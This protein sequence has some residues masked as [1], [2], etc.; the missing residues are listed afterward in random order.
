ME[1]T[2]LPGDLYERIIAEL[3]PPDGKAVSSAH[4]V[5]AVDGDQSDVSEAIE[6]LLR[7]GVLEFVNTSGSNMHVRV[8]LHQPISTEPQT[9]SEQLSLSDLEPNTLWLAY[10]V[11]GNDP[12]RRRARRLFEEREDAET[13]LEQIASVDAFSSVP[14]VENVLTAY[15]GDRNN[16]FA[17]LREEPIFHSADPPWQ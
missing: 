11:D 12:R 1:P 7:F 3:S 14:G 16:E 6:G 5:D 10:I 13:H 15:L 8:R 4:L 9:T 2:E 17:V